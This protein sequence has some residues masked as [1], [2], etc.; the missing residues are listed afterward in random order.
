MST[1]GVSTGRRWPPEAPEFAQS[2]LYACLQPPVRGAEASRARLKMSLPESLLFP[3]GP[4]DPWLYYVAIINNVLSIPNPHSTLVMPLISFSPH[5][6]E[7][8]GGWGR[9]LRIVC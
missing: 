6:R 3:I 4:L 8:L 9:S 1:Q 5:I 7:E 2:E